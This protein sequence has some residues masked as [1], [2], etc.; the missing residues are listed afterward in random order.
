MQAHKSYKGYGGI[1][2]DRNRTGVFFKISGL[3]K[4]EIDDIWIRTP[5]IKEAMRQKRQRKRQEQKLINF[6]KEAHRLIPTGKKRKT[7]G[8]KL[9]EQI[10]N[11]F[12]IAKKWREENV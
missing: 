8:Q 3:T 1:V 4:T 9:S 12:K 2:T 6:I 11:G 5:I 10:T 7:K